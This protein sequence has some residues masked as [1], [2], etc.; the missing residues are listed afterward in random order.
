MKLSTT[1]YRKNSKDKSEPALVIPSNRISMRDVDFPVFGVD[2]T[3][4]SARMLPGEEYIFPG[5]KVMEFP[6][7]QMGG[8]TPGY[9]TM[10]GGFKPLSEKQISNLW[11]QSG[12][13]GKFRTE[14]EVT[15]DNGKPYHSYYY[16][17]EVPHPVQV[18]PAAPIAKTSAIPDPMKQ[19]GFNGVLAPQVE[20]Y[21]LGGLF[22]NPLIKMAAPLVANAVAPGS[23][24]L[25]S[26]GMNLLGGSGQQPAQGQG[27]GQGMLGNIMGIAGMAKNMG[28][29]QDGGQPITQTQKHVQEKRDYFTE[30]ISANTRAKLLKENVNDPKFFQMGA[31]TSQAVVSGE[32]NNFFTPGPFG[33]YGSNANALPQ[34]V[35]DSKALVEGNT[36]SLSQFVTLPQNQGVL[37]EELQ[38]AAA[39]QMN[40]AP[41]LSPLLGPIGTLLNQFLPQAPMAM[42]E[43]FNEREA[44]RETR[45]KE[46]WLEGKM[47][48]ENMVPSTYGS[49]GDYDVNTGAFRPD[50]MTP[51]MKKGG[52]SLKKCY[53]KGG[54][55]TVSD[56]E[57]QELL[58]Q[59]VKFEIID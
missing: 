41:N 53:K 36:P 58:K 18:A 38:P 22:N 59:G 49:R 21:Q 5:K 47:T 45:R 57:I 7:R 39:G 23:G 56:S 17:P 26:M 25:V 43:K 29:F 12:G 30:Y 28:L 48:I 46:K 24:A 34:A 33:A 8:I 31:E 15:Q 9:K 1:G 11:V 2:E 54:E 27:S 32:G 44:A 55:Y 4:A 51:K 19:V 10:T 20:S 3:G 52:M 40:G 13:K 42:M 50:Q 35:A 16:Y 14:Y 6:I 37:G